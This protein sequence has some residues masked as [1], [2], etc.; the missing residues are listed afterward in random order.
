MNRLFM[1]CAA[2]VAIAFAAIAYAADIALHPGHAVYKQFNCAACHGEDAKTSTLPAYP[3]LAGQYADYLA[4][5]LKAYQRGVASPGA[6]NA[7][8]NPIMGAFASQL[9][10]TDIADVAAWLAE[11]PGDLGVRK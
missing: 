7:R 11:L 4:H 5:A 9:S 10:A 2:L 8:T 1:T 3:V 6:A